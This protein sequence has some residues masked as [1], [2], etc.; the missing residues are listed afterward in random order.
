MGSPRER[1]PELNVDWEAGSLNRAL[2]AGSQDF[3]KIWLYVDGPERILA[4]AADKDSRIQWENRY[5]HHCHGC[6]ALFDD[7]LVR[8]VIRTRYRERVEDVFGTVCRA[9]AR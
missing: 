2:E 8:D 5:S 4:W 6:L 7:P 1:I 3:L 9:A